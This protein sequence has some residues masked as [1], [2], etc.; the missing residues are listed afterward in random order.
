MIYLFYYR[1]FWD[2]TFPPIDLLSFRTD[3]TAPRQGTSGRPFFR[4]RSRRSDVVD[5]FKDIGV[6]GVTKMRFFFHE[7]TSMMIP[8]SFPSV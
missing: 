1:N 2:P 4:C 5:V 3:S 6:P 8:S 7:I